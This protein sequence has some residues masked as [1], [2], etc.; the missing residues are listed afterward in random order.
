MDVLQAS[1]PLG[2]EL[3]CG[4]TRAAS[5]RVSRSKLIP[6]SLDSS[7][8]ISNNSLLRTAS[9]ALRVGQGG[10]NQNSR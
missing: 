7:Y 6:R 4:I 2:S 3:T 5:A 1:L 8:L 9:Y 10:D